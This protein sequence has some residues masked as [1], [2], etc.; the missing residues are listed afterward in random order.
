MTILK[1]NIPAT[2]LHSEN[3]LKHFFLKVSLVTKDS[4]VG[5]ECES[6]GRLKEADVGADS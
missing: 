1:N 5:Q 4:V 2:V 3:R 6:G